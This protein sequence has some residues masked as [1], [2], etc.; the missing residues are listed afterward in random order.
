MYCLLGFVS[1]FAISLLVGVFSYSLISVVAITAVSPL[2]DIFRKVQ[3]LSINPMSV[4]TS[5]GDKREQKLDES[6]KRIRKS[7]E[8]IAYLMAIGYGDAGVTLISQA[9][10]SRGGI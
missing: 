8:K 10:G 5:V 7:L 6:L 9:L 3:E 4:V 2:E 1:Y